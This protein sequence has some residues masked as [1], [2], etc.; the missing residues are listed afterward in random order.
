MTL[1]ETTVHPD[2]TLPKTVWTYFLCPSDQEPVEDVR[3]RGGSSF[4]KTVFGD[5]VANEIL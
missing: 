3:G 1:V 5:R 2:E 4:D